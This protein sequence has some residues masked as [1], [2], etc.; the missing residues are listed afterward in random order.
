MGPTWDRQDPGGPHVGHMKLA[1]WVRSIPLDY[2]ELELVERVK[3]L[4]LYVMD[5][6]TWDERILNICQ[7]MD[8]FINVLHRLSR[9]FPRECLLEVYQSY[10][11]STLEYGFTIWGSTTD[12]NIGKIQR[13]Q[14]LAARK[15]QLETLTVSIQGMRIYIVRSRS[16]QTAK[17]R[18]DHLCAILFKCICDLAPN[19]SY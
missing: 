10:R 12:T 4:G 2:D 16:L 1:I 19:Y 3:H 6:L 18:R 11:Q 7:N 15:K 13:I 8:N 17:E 9:I 5:D 14:S